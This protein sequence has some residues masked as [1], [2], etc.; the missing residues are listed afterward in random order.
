MIPML[1]PLMFTLLQVPA[2]VPDTLTYRFEETKRSV[3]RL[4]GGEKG[5]A[6]KVAKGDSARSGD[7]VTTGWWARAVIAV[8]E[9][10]SRFEVYANTQVKLAG[11]EPGVLL[12][13]EKGR[14]KAFF[15][16]LVA[17]N[18]QERQVAV[19]G[20]LLAVRGTRYG[21]EVGKEGKSTLVVFEGVV[22]VLPKAVHAEPVRVKAGEWA[23]FGPDLLPQIQPISMRG[24][25]EKAWTQGMLP[26]GTM[27]PGAMSPGSM[28]KGMPSGSGPMHH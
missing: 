20:A 12:V 23:R 16:A 5:K 10:M 9:R 4:P 25:D 7:G 11:G 1:A 24:F 28:P 15:Q 21:V 13:V 3:Y 8:P 19:P 18:R 22:E 26:D 2:P 27:G 17:G 14:I 6:V